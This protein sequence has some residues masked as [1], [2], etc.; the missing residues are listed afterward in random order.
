MRGGDR[1][2]GKENLPAQTLTFNPSEAPEFTSCQILT[3]NTICSPVHA[4]ENMAKKYEWFSLFRLHA[5][6]IYKGIIF[7]MLLLKKLTGCTEPWPRLHPTPSGWMGMP[8]VSQTSMRRNALNTVLFG[9]LNSGSKN[10]THTNTPTDTHLP[11]A[12]KLRA[13]SDNHTHFHQRLAR[14]AEVRE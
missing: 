3:N 1:R 12:R 9:S 10:P 13:A 2:T 6:G 4:V 8:S 11:H 5:T 7:Q 14:G